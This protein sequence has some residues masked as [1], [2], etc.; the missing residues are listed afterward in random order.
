MEPVGI[1]PTS[2]SGPLAAFAAV[3]TFQPLA[4]VAGAGARK[5]RE[6]DNSGAGV[7]YPLLSI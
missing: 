7:F 1:E 4:E 2:G 3:E 6:R 5:Y